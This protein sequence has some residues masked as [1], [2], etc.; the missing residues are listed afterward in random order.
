MPEKILVVDDEPHIVTLVT[1]ALQRA[2]YA[3][4][5]AKDGLEAL[6]KVRTEHPAL[7]LL[8]VMLPGLDGFEVCERIRKYETTPIIMITAKSAEME[9]VWGL[10]VGADDYI[11]KPFSPANWWPG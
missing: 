1:V 10:E 3:A 11:T 8:D 7:V 5:S 2:G 9:K 4:V 6:E